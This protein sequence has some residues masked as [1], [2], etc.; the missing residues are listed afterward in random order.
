MPD[1]I[2]VRFKPAGPSYY[3]EPA[4]I[5]FDL[6]DLVIVETSRG[7]SMGKVV[8][9]LEQIASEDIQEPLKPVV[10][11]AESQEVTRAEELKKLEKEVLSKSAELVARHELQMKLM[12]A[13]YN[14]DGSHLTIY[15][16]AEKKIDFRNLLKELGS[17][18]KTR[19]ELRQ[20]GAR[21]AAKLLGGIGRC[22]RP[23]CCCTSLTKFD[24]IS[25]RMAHDQ[26]LPLNP[27]KISGVCGK[28]FCCL[29]Y[30]HPHYLEAKAQ[31]PSIGE[32]VTTPS[33]PAKVVGTNILTERVTVR[34][35]SEAAADFHISQIKTSKKQS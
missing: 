16:S 25:V 30:E 11:K 33:G 13:E 4:G 3:F 7:Q 24:P 28:L 5:D 21:D 18:F 2:S 22:G 9:G 35:E 12:A 10:R 1:V 27:A 29:K 31:L 32:S 34:F 17:V 26:N 14:F 15:F 8:K 23:L 6:G 19:V 20:I